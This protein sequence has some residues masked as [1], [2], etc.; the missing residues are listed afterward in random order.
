MVG[1]RFALSTRRMKAK[2]AQISKARFIVDFHLFNRSKYFNYYVFIIFLFINLILWAI[3]CFYKHTQTHTHT[4]IYIRKRKEY[5]KK[6]TVFTIFFSKLCSVPDELLFPQLPPER[7]LPACF[8]APVRVSCTRG[9]QTGKGLE[10]SG[11]LHGYRG[12]K[13]SGCG[14]SPGCAVLMCCC[15]FCCGGEAAAMPVSG[16]LLSAKFFGE[17]GLFS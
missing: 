10:T 12:Y 5:S 7:S 9:G 2:G 11:G 14:G 6:G 16:A 17:G 8:V 15:L 13:T 1:F 3:F 4:H